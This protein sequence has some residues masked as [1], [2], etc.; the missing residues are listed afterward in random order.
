MLTPGLFHPFTVSIKKLLFVVLNS[1]PHVFLQID[2]AAAA[3]T[4]CVCVHDMCAE[5]KARCWKPALCMVQQS[6]GQRT[7]S[8]A[9]QHAQHHHSYVSGLKQQIHSLRLIGSASCGGVQF[10]C[11]Q[12]WQMPYKECCHKQQYGILRV[13]LQQRCTMLQAVEQMRHKECTQCFW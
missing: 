9:N 4:Y 8:S 13:C 1:G 10:C 2:R 6:C 5:S 7:A 12:A 3:K 11:M